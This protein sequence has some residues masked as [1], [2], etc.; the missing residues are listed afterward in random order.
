MWS[1]HVL[2][3]P[4]WVICFPPAVHPHARQVDRRLCV[5]TSIVPSTR[6]VGTDDLSTTLLWFP[7]VHSGKG[8]SPVQLVC[9]HVPAQV[10]HEVSILSVGGFF[11]FFKQGLPDSFVW[12]FLFLFFF[13]E[14]FYAPVLQVI[15]QV[16][17]WLW[18][19]NIL[20]IFGP[21]IIN[22]CCVVLGALL[23]L[24]EFWQNSMTS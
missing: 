18:S 17:K 13:N 2:H 7:L 19:N 11:V 14:V 24:K 15:H 3:L 1:L 10:L 16:M 6:P 9:P 22:R 23:F 21:M 8:C 4:V 12:F 5:S 20:G